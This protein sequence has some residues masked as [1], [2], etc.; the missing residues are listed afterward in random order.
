MLFLALL[1]V[2]TASACSPSE[3]QSSQ[4]GGIA[5]SAPDG[6]P[7]NTQAIVRGS[8]SYRERMA[9][10]PDAVVDLWITDVSPGFTAA[11]ITAEANVATAG[12]QVPI[13]FE[14]PY[15]AGRIASD[16]DY[17]LRA[18]IRSGE[19]TLFS[20]E[21]PQLVITKGNPT[22]VELWLV[23]APEN[24]TKEGAAQTHSLVG[25][26]WR[27]LSI[28]GAPVLVDKV[29]ATLNFDEEGRVSGSGSCNRFSGPV[30][31]SGQSVKFG[32]LIST[33]MACADDAANDQERRYLQALQG[34]E[35]FAR[36]GAALLIYSRGVEQPLRFVPTTP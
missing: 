8:V 2:L 4:P 36:D 21:N 26:E 28:A 33:M 3:T 17:G 34:A 13:P 11:V 15:D 30:E 24:A 12:R 31:I 32:P 20:T 23:R 10:P 18:V 14:V 29:Q 35:R 5:P 19:R 6:S 7:T 9:L 27:L 22:E 1:A 16:H 25:T